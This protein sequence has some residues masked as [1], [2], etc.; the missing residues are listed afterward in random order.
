[1]RMRPFGR[2]L[3]IDRA[4]ARM[5]GTTRP[6]T[7]TERLP[8]AEALGRVSAR[9]YRARSD[10][11]AFARATWD[12]YAVRARDT[13]RAGPKN[14]VTLRVVGEVFAEET[15]GRPLRNG[16]AVAI[17]TGGAVPRGAD[18][19]VIF[20][21][22]QRTDRK[23]VLSRAVRRGE[24][25][26]AP[27]DDFRRR[28]LLLRKGAVL[29]P[30]DLGALAATGA[31]RV[32]VYRPPV[33]SLIPNGNELAGPARR[34]GRGQI[35]ESNNATLA[36]VVRAAGGEPRAIPPVP[37][38][39]RVIESAI[40]SALRTSDVVVVTGGSSVGEH[41]YLPVIFPRLGTLL[42]HGL[43][44]RP[45]KPTLAARVGRRLLIGMPGHPTSCL[46]NAFWL[47]LPTLRKIA[48]LPGPGW[49]DGT[50]QLGEALEG[51]KPPFSRIV[52]FHVE[53]GVAR[54]TFRDSS[55]IT[56]LSR[57]NAYAV[58]PPGGAAHRAGDVLA[59][60]YLLPPL[61]ADP[62]FGGR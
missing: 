23:V 55:A 31:G 17:A 3:P 38:D 37:D 44:V 42:F 20:E 59:V 12:G 9:P 5:L 16:E 14:P 52:P 15:L 30:A 39:A 54:P 11:P 50:A 56:S 60:R 13:L 43:A 19:V 36:A 49:V 53:R 10:V 2:L 35:Y 8:V 33:V 1:M 26:A 29:G 32:E 40:R 25:I 41:D 62:I 45:G 48:R 6:I 18:S 51:S 47:L 57:V 46:S 7:R 61:A 34:L 21:E 58:L 4:M 27:G 24:R 22:V 28:T